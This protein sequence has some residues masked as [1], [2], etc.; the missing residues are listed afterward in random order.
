MLKQIGLTMLV[1]A[2]L[3]SWSLLAAAEEKKVWACAADGT[4]DEDLFLV[5]WGVNSYVK[6]YDV[7]IWGNFAN[8]GDERRWDFGDGNGRIAAYSVI[9]KPDGDLDYYDFRDVDIGQSVEPAYKY[10]CRLAQS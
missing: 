5:E 9:L 4:S 7:R 1:M 6:L 10:H 2:G 3:L 8:D